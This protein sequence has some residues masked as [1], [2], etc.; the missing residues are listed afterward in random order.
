MSMALYEAIITKPGDTVATIRHLRGYG[1]ASISQIQSAIST[2]KPVVTIT[3]EDYP[4]EHDPVA[5]HALQHARFVEAIDGLI[6]LGNALELRYRP[7]SSDRH[8]VITRDT[9]KNSMQSELDR[10][11]RHYD[12]G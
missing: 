2:G 10:L 4:L 11:R 9:M 5:G 3:S 8:E 6:A 12:R 7:S 1:D